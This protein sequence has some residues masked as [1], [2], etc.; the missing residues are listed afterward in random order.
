MPAQCLNG[1]C[2]HSAWKI[3]K[4]TQII[5]MMHKDVE[6]TEDLCQSAVRDG[7][8]RQMFTEGSATHIGSGL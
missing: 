8:F 4:T 5:L 7:G 1:E 3:V 6:E 2:L